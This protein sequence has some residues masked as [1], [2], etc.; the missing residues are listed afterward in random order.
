M[1]KS[2][3]HTA[4]P[5]SCSISLTSPPPP[6]CLV[7]RIRGLRHD[8]AS[9]SSVCPEGAGQGGADGTGTRHEGDE[10]VVRAQPRLWMSPPPSSSCMM[11]RTRGHRQATLSGSDIGLEGRS[12]D[13]ADD[14]DDGSMTHHHGPSGQGHGEGMIHHHGPSSQDGSNDVNLLRQLQVPPDHIVP[15]ISKPLSYVRPME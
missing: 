10:G 3:V 15:T 8:A 13:D 12:Q 9:S 7:P 5:S 2:R 11:L 1:P 6:S 14:D 4:D